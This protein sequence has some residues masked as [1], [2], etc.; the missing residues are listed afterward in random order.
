MPTRNAR[1][2]AALMILIWSGI[3]RASPSGAVQPP[4]MFN[5]AVEPGGLSSRFEFQSMH[6]PLPMGTDEIVRSDAVIFT[7][8]GRI[9]LRDRVELG[10]NL[11]LL[12]LYL[13]RSRNDGLNVG[14]DVGNLML[15][16]KLKVLGETTGPFVASLFMDAMLPTQIF[17]D[18][19]EYGA[20][21]WGLAATG[22]RG[23]FT[24]GGD[25]GLELS[26]DRKTT[27]FLLNRFDLFGALRLHRLIALSLTFQLGT[28]LYPV[29]VAPAVAISPG[30]HLLTASGFTLCL[31]LRGA[32]TEDARVFNT[33]ARV[34]W[35][36]NIGY[37]SLYKNR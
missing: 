36:F 29:A 13:E 6:A 34:A 37:N 7:A 4:T 9:A 3:G 25:L 15:L 2:A 1:G 5:A 23:R 33:G 28:L 26:I 35:M 17:A 11:P 19:H 20:V 21:H 27:S 24:Y 31:S 30:V 10:L 8:E 14:L 12:H 18:H 16:L 22:T 32:V